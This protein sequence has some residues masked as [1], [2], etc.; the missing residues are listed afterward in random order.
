MNPSRR[1]LMQTMVAGAALVFANRI[2]SAAGPAVNPTLLKVSHSFASRPEFVRRM[3]EG[4]NSKHTDV[5]IEYVAVGDNWEPQFQST[6]RSG[7]INQLP[8]ISHQLLSYSNILASRGI[9]QPLNQMEGG[10]SFL[11]SLGVADTLMKAGAANGNAYAVPFGLTIPVIYYNMD[12]LRKAGWSSPTPPKTWEEINKVA[13]NIA[14]LGGNTNG[15]YIEYQAS[16]NWMFQSALNSIGG[17][18]GSDGS[19]LGFDASLGV[20]AMQIIADF[21]RAAGTVTMTRDQARQAFSAGTLG[22]LFRSASGIP[23]A[24]EAAKTNQYELGI[25]AFPLGDGGFVSANSHGIYIFTTDAARQRAALEYIKWACAPEGQAIQAEYAGYFPANTTALEE[26]ALF[27]NYFVAN[28]F[29]RDLVGSL[30]AA[31]DWYSYPVE[32][33]DQIFDAQIDIVRRV[34]VG[35]LTPKDAIAEMSVET[36]RLMK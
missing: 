4:F 2:A 26:S 10:G 30:A 23:A 31:R 35:Q 13:A 21:A 25:S 36:Q 24:M 8:D 32:N 22:V 11:A 34:V 14:T 29:A 20:K 17:A 19:P 18:M 6:L 12:L 28:P 7:I 33:S 15:G 9:A 16:K 5:K 27:S 3:E 1:C